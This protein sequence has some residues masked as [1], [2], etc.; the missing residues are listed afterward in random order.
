M[1]AQTWKEFKLDY[2]HYFFAEKYDEWVNAD[3][4]DDRRVFTNMYRMII[5]ALNQLPDEPDNY[6]CVAMNKSMHEDIDVMKRIM[7][8][9]EGR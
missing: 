1:N 6:I 7:R 5:N 9:F 4:H 2:M 3:V 8:H